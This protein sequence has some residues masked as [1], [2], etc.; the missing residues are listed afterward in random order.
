MGGSLTTM[1]DRRHIPWDN[2]PLPAWV[3]LYYGTRRSDGATGQLAFRITA[4]DQRDA[5]SKTQGQ[6]NQEL[7]CPRLVSASLDTPTDA[8]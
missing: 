4:R 3:V 6:A 7:V 8:A 1:D 2:A 5:I